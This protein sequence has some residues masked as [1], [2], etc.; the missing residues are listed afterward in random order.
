MEEPRSKYEQFLY[1]YEKLTNKD[2][3][4]NLNPSKD[5]VKFDMLRP[6]LMKEVKVITLKSREDLTPLMIK[7]IMSYE[8]VL[9][10]SFE[11]VMGIDSAKFQAQNLAEHYGDAVVDIVT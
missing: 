11:L 1:K 6:E 3:K 2:T 4:F 8:V 7:E 10:R 5:K 9:L